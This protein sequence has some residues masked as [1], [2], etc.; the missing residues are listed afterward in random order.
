MPTASWMHASLLLVLID[1]ATNE[2]KQKKNVRQQQRAGRPSSI[3]WL[4]QEPPD[5]RQI[6]FM[7]YY[8][9]VYMILLVQLYTIRVTSK[10]LYIYITCIE[11]LELLPA[12]SFGA[13]T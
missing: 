2:I 11:A 9:F 4:V 10:L 6:I 1:R 7:F 5:K 8:H 12:V 13:P 3:S